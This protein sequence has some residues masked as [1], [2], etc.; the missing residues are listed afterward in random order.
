ML[1]INHPMRLGSLFTCCISTIERERAGMDP[2]AP[3]AER[4]LCPNCNRTLT[5][6]RGAWE[7]LRPQ[8]PNPTT[9]TS[10]PRPRLTLPR[11]M[12]TNRQ[13]R[14]VQQSLTLSSP[15]LSSTLP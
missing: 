5:F 11:T 7:W 8:A 4:L 3:E 9:L 10:L 15:A 12:T 6:T 1:H 14:A 13:S 2:H